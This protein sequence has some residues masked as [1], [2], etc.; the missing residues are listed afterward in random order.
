MA[1]WR[2]ILSTLWL[3]VPTRLQS[4]KIRSS[5]KIM[6]RNWVS[7]FTLNFWYLFQLF[8]KLI[9][10]CSTFLYQEQFC[11]GYPCIN[12]TDINELI[13]IINARTRFINIHDLSKQWMIIMTA[14]NAVIATCSH[15]DSIIYLQPYT[16][17]EVV[18]LVNEHELT[19]YILRSLSVPSTSMKHY[20]KNCVT[21]PVA[22]R[23]A[24]KYSRWHRLV[25]P[26]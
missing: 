16:E 6:P 13:A 7:S 2:R 3:H 19:L 22:H 17:S 26:L 1:W 9:V 4:N 20:W 8:A 10:F 25:L 14:F 18:R 5:K 23:E 24:I 12:I 15:H 21:M 11:Y